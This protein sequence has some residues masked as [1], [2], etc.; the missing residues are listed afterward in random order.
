[1]PLVTSLPGW[2]RLLTEPT[3]TRQRSLMGGAR[4]MRGQAGLGLAEALASLAGP[5]DA[6]RTAAWAP[7]GLMH[8]ARLIPDRFLLAN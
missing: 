3:G 4:L 7:F 8:R 1:M 2:Q 5:G 6:R